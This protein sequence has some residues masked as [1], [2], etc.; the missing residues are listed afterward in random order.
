MPGLRQ[1][2]GDE[3]LLCAECEE[4][5][6]AGPCAACEAMICADCGVMTKDPNG[7]KVICA[8]CANLV[9]EVSRRKL[10]RRS[11]SSV[12]IAVAL[13]VVVAFGVAAL[14]LSG[15]CFSPE[16]T[17]GLLC[18]DTR[19]CPEGQFCDLPSGTCVI[20]APPADASSARD[21]A[22]DGDSG[23]AETTDAGKLACSE[24]NITIEGPDGECYMYFSPQLA[25]AAG[26]P[27]NGGF[28]GQQDCLELRGAGHPVP[29]TWND[30][31]CAT[32]QSYVC[33]REP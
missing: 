27:N 22:T 20:G 21:G 12:G 9:A 18:S 3:P 23:D 32:P 10:S 24:G 33:E 4:R 13:L 25:E 7:R 16:I 1:R 15:S 2:D 31:N 26:E 6:P 14:L 5:E 19:E 30:E 29:L 17:T 11:R 28:L 8:S